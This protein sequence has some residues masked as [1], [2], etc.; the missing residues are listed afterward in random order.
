[1][2]DAAG[3]M[4]FDA[5]RVPDARPEWFEPTWWESKGNIERL[6]GGRGG[7]HR[8]ET[9]AG[10][11]VLRHYHRGGM[12]AVLLGDR[13]RWHGEDRTR[14]FR[15][16]RLLAW[17]GAHNLPVPEVFAARYQRR[18][19][20]YTADLLTRC[21]DDARTLAEVIGANELDETL[22]A[23][24]G[25]MVARFHRAG[26]FHADLNAHNILMNGDGLHLID[27]DRGGL[28][29]P[30]RSWQWSNL[31]RLRRSFLKL[32]AC[33]G[34]PAELDSTVWPALTSAWREAMQA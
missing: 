26:V 6:G 22:A 17:L 3:A 13:Y 34:N 1:M 10:L 33:G 28:R 14:S 32:G 20:H 25:A 31:R 18:G 15:E 2:T 9:P 4:V 16:F 7:V 21:I 27:F 11:A 29:R 19:S 30:A 24:V 23:A 8:V 5:V 12:M